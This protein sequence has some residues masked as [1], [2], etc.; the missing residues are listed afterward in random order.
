MVSPI[1]ETDRLR[2]FYRRARTGPLLITFA[3]NGFRQ[4]DSFFGETPSVAK[5]FTRIGIVAKGPDW[6]P[7]LEM[8]R[9]L[10]YLAEIAG[11]HDEVICLGEGAGGYAALKYSRTLG[12][13]L[14]IGLSPHFSIAPDDVGTFDRRHEKHFDPEL[15]AGMAIAGEDVCETAFVIHDPRD[16]HERGHAHLIAARALVQIVAAPHCAGTVGSL[17]TARDHVADMIEMARLG[18]T[19]T[20]FQRRIRLLKKGWPAYY[21]RLANAVAPRGKPA[22]AV[23]LLERARVL[24]RANFDILMRLSTLQRRLGRLNEAETVAR[25]L[26]TYHPDRAPP[27]ILL[28]DA[29]AEKGELQK[30]HDSLET[31]LTINPN[32]PGLHLSFA[33]LLER[34]GHGAQAIAALEVATQRFPKNERLRSELDRLRAQQA[35][36]D[37]TDAQSGTAHPLSS[38]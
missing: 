14:A 12:A 13:T 35:T 30:A 1:I 32:L 20:R 2:I 37:A 38:P 11:R 3:G 9:Y 24:D 4:T 36:D 7:R 19:P 5:A 23:R 15:H 33:T 26:I 6:Y 22:V 17:L 25:T 16:A 21:L 8:E 10:D 31:A 29:L 18:L 28:S 27:H 34:L